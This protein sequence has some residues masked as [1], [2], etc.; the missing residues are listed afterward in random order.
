MDQQEIELDNMLTTMTH[1]FLAEEEIKFSDCVQDWYR[2]NFR[3]NLVPMPKDKDD[4]ILALKAS[5][6]DR[7]VEVL[8]SPPHL[9]NQTTPDWCSHIKAI[10][11]PRKLQDDMLLSDG[12]YCEAFAKRNLYV[13]R[14]FMFFV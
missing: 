3:C 9:G 1:H 2:R 12:K 6:I 11:I 4:F 5:I 8:N 13:T 14:N 7:L 10:N